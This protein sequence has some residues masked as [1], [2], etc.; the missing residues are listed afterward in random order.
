[1]SSITRKLV[2][3]NYCKVYIIEILKRIKRI[4]YYQ[5]KSTSNFFKQKK[6]R[7]EKTLESINVEADSYVH[8]NI[9]ATNPRVAWFKPVSDL[10]GSG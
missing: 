2:A 8:A 5:N 9:L 1:M 6:E 10:L 3:S 7:F 4:K